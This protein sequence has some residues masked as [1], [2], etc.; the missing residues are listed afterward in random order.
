LAQAFLIHAEKDR[1]DGIGEVDGEMFFF[2][3]LDEQGPEFE[4]VFFGGTGLGIHEA[5]HF[6]EGGGVIGFGLGDAGFYGVRV[7]RSGGAWQK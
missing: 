5:L 1:F 7:D 2:V 6:G 4:L 3:V